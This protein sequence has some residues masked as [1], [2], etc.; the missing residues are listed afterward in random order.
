MV[1]PESSEKGPLE[2]RNGRSHGQ[3]FGFGPI[4]MCGQ[5]STLA[6]SINLKSVTEHPK[7]LFV[8]IMGRSSL[9][10]WPL[11][12]C[13]GWKDGQIFEFLFFFQEFHTQLVYLGHNKRYRSKTW[14]QVHGG[15]LIENGGARKIREGN[16]GGS[17]M[18]CVL[19]RVYFV[20]IGKSLVQEDPSS[21]SNI[22]FRYARG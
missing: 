16:I 10:R 9:W 14:R 7:G 6:V 3:C 22:G 15:V 19:R 11:K 20:S 12:F 4:S 2:D 5:K 13:K 17:Y 8:T 1:G 21:C 18:A